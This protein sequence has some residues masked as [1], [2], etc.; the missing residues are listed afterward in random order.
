M[1]K[2]QSCRR[3]GCNTRSYT[4][5]QTP[6]PESASVLYRPSDRRL[7][8]K[9]QLLRIDGVSC[10]QRGGS[11]YGRNFGFLDRSRYFFFQATPYLYSRGWVDPV[12][13]PLLLRKSG[14]AANRTWTSGSLAKNSDHY[15][16]EA[17]Q[18]HRDIN[19]QCMWDFQKIYRPLLWSSGQS[20]WPQI[21]RPGFDSRHYQKK[22]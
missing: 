10:S 19:T 18:K 12:P 7:S 14:S 5:Q 15:T 8:A 21:R 4:K 6:R 20:S 11:P 13:D 9:C 1:L 17:V 3:S 16:K 22:K 2:E